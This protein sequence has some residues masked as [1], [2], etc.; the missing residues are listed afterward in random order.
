MTSHVCIEAVWKLPANIGQLAPD[1]LAL[2]GVAE[3]WDDVPLGGV[4]QARLEPVR[5]KHVQPVALD[6]RVETVEVDVPHLMIMMMKRT[7][8]RLR[9]MMRTRTRTRPMMRTRI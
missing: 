7:R 9:T 6:L 3:V 5:G 8:T 1:P 4:E 2:E